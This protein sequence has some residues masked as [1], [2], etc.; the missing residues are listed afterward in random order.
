LE[1]VAQAD[2]TTGLPTFD[3]DC[4]AAPAGTRFTIRLDNRDANTHNVDILDQPGGI[5][6]FTGRIVKGPKIVTYSVKPIDPGTY[7]FR[8][9]VHPLRMNG[10]FIVA[11]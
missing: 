2:A 3:R 7:Y 10:T 1:I 8:C 4:L 9:D 5:P 11:G 6:F